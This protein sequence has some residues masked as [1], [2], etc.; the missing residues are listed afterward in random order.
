MFEPP[1]HEHRPGLV[2]PVRVDPTGKNGP[3]R[4]QARGPRW[5]S[6]SHGLVVP[7]SVEQTPEQRIVEAAAVLRDGEAVTGWGAPRWRGG[8]WFDGRTD[9]TETRNVPLVATRHLMAQPGFSISQEFLSPADVTIHD[10]VPITHSVRAVVFEMRYAAGLGDAITALDMACY[11][12]FVSIAEVAGYLA[13]LGPVTGIGQAREAVARAHE[14]SW[15][16]R[17][18]SMRGVWTRFAGL[19]PPLCNAPVFDMAGRHVGTPDLIDPELGLVAQYNGADHINLAGV[20]NDISTEA[21]F[22]ALGLECVTMLATDWG[23]LD[24]FTD[25]LLDAAR[26]AQRRTAAPGWTV[27]LPTWW[28]P[29]GTVEL[30]RGL[31]EWQRSRYLRYR[32]AA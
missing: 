26:R 31:D 17:E 29:T 11:S 2:V 18:S 32:R 30:R 4:G 23:A 21:A 15:S 6:S 1:S 7:A 22:R 28:T 5:R 14:N 3:T 19:A 10:G 16:P 20:A 9:G 24:A 27:E 8:A 12:D 25:R 13:G